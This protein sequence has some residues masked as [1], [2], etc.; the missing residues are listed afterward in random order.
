[1]A[2]HLNSL[3]RK[4]SSFDTFY[5]GV[6]QE[7]KNWTVEPTLPRRKTIPQRFND[8][9]QAHQ[10][11]S[12]K[13]RYRHV[14]FDVLDLAAGEVGRRFDHED[15]HLMKEIEILLLNRFDALSA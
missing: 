2:T 13:T 5:D 6:C 4:D 3:F 14:Y 8:G 12:P 7:S 11:E 15:L 9:G 10:Y 1:M